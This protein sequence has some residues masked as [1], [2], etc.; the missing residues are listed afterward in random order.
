MF[1][2][3]NPFMAAS[4]FFRQICCRQAFKIDTRTR[5]KKRS[6]NSARNPRLQQKSGMAS[7]AAPAPSDIFATLDRHLTSLVDCM[8]NAVY[9]TMLVYFVNTFIDRICLTALIVSPVESWKGLFYNM[10]FSVAVC[11]TMMALKDTLE[12]LILFENAK[13]HRD[14]RKDA[15]TIISVN[16]TSAQIKHVDNGLSSTAWETVV[17]YILHQFLNKAGTNEGENTKDA[18]TKS[19][20]DAKS[21]TTPVS[22]GED[23]IKQ[24]SASASSSARSSA[25]TVDTPN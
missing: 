2:K 4:I 1:S 15:T 3:K 8:R 16:E 17:G 9:V 24:D 10:W 25:D 21:A 7:P 22:T 5:K 20:D 18:S 6:I 14:G 11:S 19:E 13:R 23:E 12:V